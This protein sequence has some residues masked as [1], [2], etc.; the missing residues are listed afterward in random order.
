MSAGQTA[1]SATTGTTWGSGK[2]KFS[3]LAETEETAPSDVELLKTQIRN[4]PCGPATG[5]HDKARIKLDRG[6]HNQ[7]GSQAHHSKQGGRHRGGPAHIPSAGSTT[8]I[9]P[10]LT[11]QVDQPQPPKS[12]PQPGPAHGKA[13]FQHASSKDKLTP[14]VLSANSLQNDMEVDPT[15]I[16]LA[17]STMQAPAQ[18]KIGDGK[19]PQDTPMVVSVASSSNLPPSS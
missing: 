5:G 17:S 2:S 16:A 13:P 9:I 14:S 19:H 15:Q 12:T 6:L 3:I 7:K 8:P 18:G 11:V 10:H 1:R 4:I